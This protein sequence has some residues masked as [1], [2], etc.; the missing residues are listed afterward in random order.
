MYLKVSGRGSDAPGQRGGGGIE[1]GGGAEEGGIV[2]GEVVR[3]G[4]QG[5]M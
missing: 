3:V 4:C 5:C 1:E 2:E